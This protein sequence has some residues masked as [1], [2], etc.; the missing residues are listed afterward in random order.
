[1]TWRWHEI[2]PICSVDHAGSPVRLIYICNLLVVKFLLF[3]LPRM[4]LLIEFLMCLLPSGFP[5]CYG[6][7]LQH[8]NANLNFLVQR[9]EIQMV[10]CKLWHRDDVALEQQLNG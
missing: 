10:V 6:A 3:L 8:V 2:M 5:L 7:L 1:M 9:W 4:I